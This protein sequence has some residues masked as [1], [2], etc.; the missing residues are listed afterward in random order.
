M[1]TYRKATEAE[2]AAL[3]DEPGAPHVTFMCK[4]GTDRTWSAKNIALSNAG[5]YSG[6][7][8]IFY[9]HHESGGAECKCPARDL[10]CV[11]ED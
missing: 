8:H 7:R 6:A 10:Y 5:G 11:V 1:T 3:Q 4:C 9:N 2:I